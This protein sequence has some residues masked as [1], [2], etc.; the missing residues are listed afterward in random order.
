MVTVVVAHLQDELPGL[1]VLTGFGDRADP[2]WQ[3]Q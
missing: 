3:A 2:R 1:S